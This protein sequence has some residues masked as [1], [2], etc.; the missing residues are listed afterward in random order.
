MSKFRVSDDID[1]D[2]KC[3]ER[4]RKSKVVSAL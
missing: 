4:V 2:R 1:E 3:C